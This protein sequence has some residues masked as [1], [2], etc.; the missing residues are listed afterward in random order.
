MNL[1]VQATLVYYKYDQNISIMGWGGEEVLGQGF[2][3]PH[4]RTLFGIEK[5]T[6][7]DRMWENPENFW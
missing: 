7:E 4:A 5:Y 2:S 6:W 3:N 1:Q